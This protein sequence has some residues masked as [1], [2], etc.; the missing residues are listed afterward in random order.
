MSKFSKRTRRS[1]AYLGEM[2]REDLSAEQEA[3][4]S[5]LS[6]NE[7]L[8]IRQALDDAK[9]SDRYDQ[10][11][12][13]YVKVLSVPLTDAA[14]PLGVPPNSLLKLVRQG[15]VKAFKHQNRWRMWL[16]DFQVD[17]KS[18]Y[19]QSLDPHKLGNKRPLSWYW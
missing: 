19:V 16:F 4:L 14:A 11:W 2:T 12:D 5:G 15:W 7:M 17:M 18:G 8:T 10:A 6:V 3:E 9:G 13:A 1:D